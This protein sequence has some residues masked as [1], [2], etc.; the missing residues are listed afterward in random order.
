LG[1]LGAEVV[2]IEEPE[3]DRQRNVAKAAKNPEMGSIFM[4]LNRNS[5]PWC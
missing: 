4:A 2:K 1:D 5:D 3:G